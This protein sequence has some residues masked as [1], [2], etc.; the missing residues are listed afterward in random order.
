MAG[1][2]IRDLFSGPSTPNPTLRDLASERVAER[3]VVP[4]ENQTFT[5]RIPGDSVEDHPLVQ[6]QLG[7]PFYGLSPLK[8][9][10]LLRAGK[11]TA[12]QERQAR[13][14]IDQYQKLS[15][16]TVFNGRNHDFEEPEV[17]GDGGQC[18]IRRADP[19]PFDGS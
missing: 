6:S 3:T 18:G 7:N 8:V 14:W 19:Y 1:K 9:S 10:R 17:V 2:S 16:E 13:S 5:A 15:G 11:L 4:S 12:Q